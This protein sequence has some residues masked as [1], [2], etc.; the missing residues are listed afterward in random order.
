[1]ISKFLAWKILG[2]K[3]YP[4][5]LIISC[6]EES[7]I[8]SRFYFGVEGFRIQ[9][10]VHIQ[11]IC[12]VDSRIYEFQ[13][14]EIIFNCAYTF[15]IA[16]IQKLAQLGHMGLQRMMGNIICNFMNKFRENYYAS[17]SAR[18]ALA[19]AKPCWVFFNVNKIY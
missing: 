2:Q 19:I 7:C 14:E 1:M 3:N 13:V 4:D 5:E 8:S 16:R 17:I 10:H 11:W 15:D 18:K 6:H 9:F 12:Q